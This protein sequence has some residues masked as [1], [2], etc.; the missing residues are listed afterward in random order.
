MEPKNHQLEKEIH[1]PSTSILGSSAVSFPGFSGGDFMM[2]YDDCP[3]N[4]SKSQ[5]DP[6]VEP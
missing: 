4:K 5:D 2:I 6:S 1:L 3:W